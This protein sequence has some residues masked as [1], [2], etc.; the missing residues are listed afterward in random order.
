VKREGYSTISKVEVLFQIEEPS[1]LDLPWC[2]I[3]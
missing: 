1:D 3:C 2:G